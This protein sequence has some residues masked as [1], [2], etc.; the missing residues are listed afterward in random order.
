MSDAEYPEFAKSEYL[1]RYRRLRLEMVA[2]DLDA[3]LVTNEL[4]NL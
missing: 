2:D 1:E 3:I 4:N